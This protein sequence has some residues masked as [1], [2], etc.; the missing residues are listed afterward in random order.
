MATR[1]PDG[2]AIEH[3]G[4]IALGCRHLF[5]STQNCFPQLIYDSVSRVLITAD[6]RLDNRNELLAVL[7]HGSR[8]LGDAQLILDAYLE[9][10]EDCLEKLRGD[11]AFAIWNERT[12]TL[13]CARDQLGAKGFSYTSAPGFFAFATESA[14]LSFLPGV[15]SALCDHLVANLIVPGFHNMVSEKTWYEDVYCLMPGTKLVFRTSLDKSPKVSRYWQLEPTEEERFGSLNECCEA[16]RDIFRQAVTSRLAGSSAALMLSGGMDSGAIAAC[17]QEAGGYD[18]HMPMRSYSTISD[19]PSSC[20][21]SQ[22]ILSLA[23][24]ECF[25][26]NYLSVPSFTGMLSWQDIEELALSAPHPVDN[27]ILLPMAMAKAAASQGHKVLVHGVSGDL[28]QYSSGAYI[29]RVLRRQGLI[30]G[31][32]ECQAASRNHT[33]LKHRSSAGLFLQNAYIAF[34]PASLRQKIRRLRQRET[35][36][37]TLIN[38]E[39][40]LKAGIGPATVGGG[41]QEGRHSDVFFQG[42]KESVDLM[43]SGLSAYDRICARFG[44]ES[45]DPWADLRVV[46]FF[47]RLPHQFKVNHGWT[48][49]VVRSTFKNDLGVDFVRRSGKEHLGYHFHKRL[50]AERRDLIV[51]VRNNYLPSLAMYYNLTEVEEL[52]DNYLAGDQS[53]YGIVYKVVCVVLWLKSL[54]A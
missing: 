14:P 19:N 18:S 2:E 4:S 39:F 9:W 31:W 20:V 26:P 7:G 44:M 5:T 36:D 1:G 32:E 28:V 48:K 16:F 27:S 25:S 54:K 47:N 15:S 41:S 11:F 53:L 22:K 49:Y 10:G 17:I 43:A 21:E 8:S 13:F 34:V 12:K 37:L 52:F 46:E 6:V 42:F 50:M 33:F 29:S 40:A 30:R 3:R 24:K 23:K 38:P 51:D 45:R 35:V